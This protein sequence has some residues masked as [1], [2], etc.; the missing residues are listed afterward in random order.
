MAFPLLFLIAASAGWVP[1]RWI[2]SEPGSLELLRGTPV[3]CL[4][5]ERDQWAPEFLAAAREKGIVVLGVVRPGD[6]LDGARLAARSK[7]D[8]IALEG[9]FSPAAVKQ[10]RDAVPDLTLVPILPRDS[11][12]FRPGEIAATFQA[13]WPEIEVAQDGATLAGPTRGPWVNTNTGFLR[14]ARASTTTPVWLANLPPAGRILPVRAYLRAIC[15][16]AF[17]GGQWVLALDED[18][19][20]RLLARSESAL[21]GWKQIVSLLAY[22][23]QHRRWR[24]LVPAGR[25]AL[26]ESP[27]SGALLSGGILDMLAVKNIPA[28][29]APASKLSTQALHGAHM[30]LD[31][32]PNVRERVLEDFAA[33]G[34]VLLSAPPG[35]QV[36]PSAREPFRIDQAGVEQLSD[37]WRDVTKAVG[38]SN[39]GVRLFN[40]S[41][42]VS[43][44]F[45]APDNKGLLLHLLNYSDYPVEDVT[46]HLLGSFTAVTLYTPDSPPRKLEARRG[47][48]TTEVEIDRLSNCATLVVE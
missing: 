48:G 44:L 18:F 36:R 2:S 9:D 25:L 20:R 11:L 10:V 29:V 28:V 41:M 19:R 13:V 27:E 24:G 1:A 15:E 45:T 22:L 23:E 33:A 7:L 4:L 26:V 46:V 37:V 40:A 39:M 35:P 16:S 3:N 14:Y 34:G 21:A 32:R 31:L 42:I 5:L 17:A 6:P 12:R 38:R 43:A 47:E 30:V 8:G